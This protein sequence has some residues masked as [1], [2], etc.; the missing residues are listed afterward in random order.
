M[1]ILKH[2]V[3]GGVASLVKAL[4]DSPS[5]ASL[6]E[7]S[8]GAVRAMAK[9]DS[10]LPLSAI[11]SPTVASAISSAV[12]DSRLDAAKDLR[13]LLVHPDFSAVLSDSFQDAKLV[14]AGEPDL[15]LIPCPHCSEVFSI[16]G[17]YG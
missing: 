10:E 17:H 11:F 15:K 3:L 5:M 7:T 1:T 13:E 16:T 9:L 14:G 12:T 2:I 4:V 6:L 8:L